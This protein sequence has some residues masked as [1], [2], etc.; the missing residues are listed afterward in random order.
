MAKPQTFDIIAVSIPDN[1]VQMAVA[2][3]M[4]GAD[5]YLS[6]QAALERVKAPTAVLFHNSDAR[7]AEQHVAKLKSLGVS[8]R[9]VRSDD[10]TED[11]DLM[12]MDEPTAATPAVRDKTADSEKSKLH[13]PPTGALSDLSA[14]SNASAQRPAA[15]SMQDVIMR[16]RYGPRSDAGGG[17]SSGG[18]AGTGR[19]AA[20]GGL[21]ALRQNEEKARRKSTIVSVI[22]STIVV[23]FAVLFYLAP[24]DS[25]RV[26]K[27]T[28]PAGTENAKDSK[29]DQGKPQRDPTSNA[30]ADRRGNVNNR[31]RQQADN[32]V[33]S[34]RTSGE[35]ANAD[36]EKQEA[37]YKIAISFN[38]Y[39]IQA[40][41]G[42]LQTYRSM[43][44]PR[45]AR[46]TEQEMVEIFGSE[47]NS[48]SAA[49][50]QFGE[51]SDAYASD[52]GAYHVEYKTKKTAKDDIL[53]DVF[54]MT[55]AVRNSCHCQNIT[56][57]AATPHN[58]KGLTVTSTAETP[59]HTLHDF[60]NRA[61]I[62]WDE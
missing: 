36:L 15:E 17:H 53:R 4:V 1:N 56:I 52:G 32:Y 59:V 44:K 47:V 13:A 18:H 43:D 11:D 19:G 54:N 8:F 27:I 12:V 3:L 2:R 46:E 23:M 50:T 61:S 51:L 57:H 25:R 45:E 39:N 34:A 9:V 10:G 26:S 49:V 31:Q 38:R 62:T 35:N 30:H 58:G 5:R 16:H 42:L 40:W 20:I 6:M 37:F 29:K 21:N 22:L 48:I 33:D 7:E 55:R 24:K 60:S 28:L 41:H 14:Y